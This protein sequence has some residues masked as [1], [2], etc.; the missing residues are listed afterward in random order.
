MAKRNAGD[1]GALK[2]TA[3]EGAAT[4]EHVSAPLPTNKEPLEATF[5]DG[6]IKAYQ[7]QK[8]FGGLAPIAAYEQQDTGDL[9]YRTKCARADSL[10]LAEVTPLSE[11]GGVR[12]KE[13]A[14]STFASLAT[15]SGRA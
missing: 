10:E 12:C 3:T 7:E 13:Q 2:L 9:D 5:A 1:L 15:G 11:D 6:F 8:V 4:V 14:S